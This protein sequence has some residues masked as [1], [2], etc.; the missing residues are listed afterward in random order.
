MDEGIFR[1]YGITRLEFS[2][3]HQ[4]ETLGWITETVEIEYENRNGDKIK[5]D[6]VRNSFS[7]VQRQ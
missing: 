6:T 1:F 2:N 4:L 5:L 3:R 7:Y